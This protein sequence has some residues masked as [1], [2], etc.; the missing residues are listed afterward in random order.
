MQALV[1]TSYPDHMAQSDLLKKLMDAGVAAAQLSRAKA[2]SIVKDFVRN[3]EVQAEQTTD[4]IEDL[5][6]RSRANT[7]ALMEM[8]RG[9]VV[10]TLAAVGINV[11]SPEQAA[12]PS[13]EQAGEPSTKKAEST[14]K[15]AG[16]AATR[17]V[18]NVRG[19]AR[20]A[21]AGM[22]EVIGDVA[23]DVSEFYG[24]V[25]GQAHRAA[26]DV[27]SGKVEEKAAKRVSRARKV[28]ADVEG[29]L[30]D[31]TSP[32]KRSP[33]STR[34]Q[35]ATKRSGATK[36][37]GSAAA[38]AKSKA[39]KKAQVARKAASSSKP[40]A[41]KSATAK[42][43]TVATKAKAANKTAAVKAPVAKKVTASE[44]T[45]ASKTSPV[46]ASAPQSTPAA[47]PSEAPVK[48]VSALSDSDTT[49]D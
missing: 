2:E 22:A 17:R 37:A 9:E 8:V 5:L 43:A 31:T 4:Q 33:A 28:V 26:N 3:G 14:R 27:R 18:A 1:V 36:K 30:D 39:T 24:N 25:A 44:S 7:E 15:K 13:P 46:S 10:S 47:K 42:R 41:T 20:R 45:V 19:V 23:D 35:A 12:E 34:K 29:D 40:A 6:A 11:P 38:G 49:S 32:A 48:R 21:T 16:T